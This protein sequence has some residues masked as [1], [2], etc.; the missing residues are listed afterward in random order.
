MSNE[1]EEIE[2]HVQLV[3]NREMGLK[4]QIKKQSDKAFFLKKKL[5][6]STHK[7][8]QLLGR[9]IYCM[10][11]DEEF[12]TN[13]AWDYVEE[14]G[15]FMWKGKSDLVGIYSTIGDYTTK[16][17]ITFKAHFTQYGS[18]L[19]RAK[20][21]T[22]ISYTGYFRATK[23]KF[24]LKIESTTLAPYSHTYSLKFTPK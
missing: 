14:Q 1:I 3:P 12:V 11:D 8:I 16:Q 19:S 22:P 7:Y 4:S 15:G 9:L 23:D 6:S 2:E 18:Y 5:D 24:T 17:G 10:E 21:N 20:D 13:L